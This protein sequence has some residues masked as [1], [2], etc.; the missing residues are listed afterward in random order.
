M[1]EE[2]QPSRILLIPDKVR[3]RGGDE[4][5]IRSVTAVVNGSGAEEYRLISRQLSHRTKKKEIQNSI[6]VQS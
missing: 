4:Y 6:Y 1:I 3:I 2:V 5:P